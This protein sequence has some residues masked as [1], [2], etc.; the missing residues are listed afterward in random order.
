MLRSP[1]YMLTS[2]LLPSILLFSLHSWADTCFPLILHGHS[3]GSQRPQL[4]H[5]PYRNLSPGPSAASLQVG[6]V[7]HWGVKT[8]PAP[9]RCRPLHHDP[10]PALCVPAASNTAPQQLTSLRILRLLCCQS[11]AVLDWS[12]LNKSPSTW[13][14]QLQ[15]WEAGTGLCLLSTW[16]VT[17]AFKCLL[18]NTLQSL[19]IRCS[20]GKF[21]PSH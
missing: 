13:Q 3:P 11:Q 6:T 14:Q 5:L 4:S 2:P 1:L 8:S 21:H 15:W 16:L 17:V 19:Q 20:Q 10:L 12:R 7:F 18:S 9:P